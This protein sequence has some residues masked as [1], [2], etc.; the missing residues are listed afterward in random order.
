MSSVKLDVALPAALPASRTEP[1]EATAFT[2]S[3]LVAT[4]CAAA[5][6]LLVIGS[7]TGVNRHLGHDAIVEGPLPPPV[8]LGVFLAGWLVMVAAMMLPGA[9]PALAPRRQQARFLGGFGLVWAAAGVAALGLD[10]LVHEAA[11]GIPAV[12][13]RPAVVGASLLAVAGALQ[14]A[15]STRR[16]RAV[17][18]RSTRKG[19]GSA[20]FAAGRDHG[21]HGLR[22]DGPLM[23]VMFGVG[24]NLAFMALLTGVMAAQRSSRWGGQVAFASGLAL[25]AAAV[26][27]GVDPS[28]L[29][30]PF[31]AQPT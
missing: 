11:D 26:L 27:V 9:Q 20:A 3:E 21:I 10:T 29:P 7:L 5:W 17:A 15:P 4:A 31:D 28:W 18:D 6:A 24:M 8:G 16:A 12:A 19:E 1:A 25:L 23:L 13:S 30:S 14:L 2:A 22:A